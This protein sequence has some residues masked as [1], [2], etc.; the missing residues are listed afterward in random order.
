[1]RI[2]FDVSP[3]VWHHS[4]GLARLAESLVR[5]LEQRARL[6]VV[7]L[8]PPSGAG[9]VNW[10]QSELPRVAKELS[11]EGVHSFVSALPWRGRFARVQTIHEVPWRHGAAE[12]AGLRHRFWASV[13]RRRADLTLVPSQ[14]V[15]RDLGGGSSRVRVCPWGVDGAFTEE[16]DPSCV[17]EL[18]LG[19]Y[20][21][22]EDPLVL[23]PGAVREKK[24]LAAVIR[25]LAEL[26]KGGGSPLHLVVTGEDTPSLRRDLGLVSRLKLSRFV[27]TPG[28]IEE[29]DL[30]S[31]LRLST[32][33]AVLSTSEGFAFPV[34]EAMACGTP[35]VV[36][37]D[38]AQAE[39]AGPLG[40][41]VDP[42]D[43][44]SVAAGLSRA[45]KERSALRGKL[46][47]RARAFSWDRCAAQ[48]EDAWAEILAR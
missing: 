31:L 6:D 46:A 39:L 38:S 37:A 22:G 21:L 9:S 35:V 1:V 12:N 43:P 34:L 48:V 24:N 4:R 26:H 2:G 13:G 17:D 19:R 15:A 8:A 32:A 3:L 30:P 45:L 7:R 28:W 36:P 18:V 27:S 33:V 40:I 23:C 16:P 10:R 11:V 41:E 20:R 14:H 5:T 47:D 29:R 42:T 44:S 25:G